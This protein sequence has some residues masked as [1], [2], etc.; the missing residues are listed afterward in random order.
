MPTWGRKPR[1]AEFLLFHKTLSSHLATRARAW[2]TSRFWPHPYTPRRR[3]QSRRSGDKAMKQA[4][5]QT[6][7]IIA[8]YLSALFSALGQR[9][10]SASKGGVTAASRSNPGP[11]MDWQAWGTQSG[12]CWRATRDGLRHLPAGPPKSCA[13]ENRL[14]PAPR[15]ARQPRFPARRATISVEYLSQGIRTKTARET[16]LL[17]RNSFLRCAPTAGAG[18]KCAPSR[19]RALFASRGEGGG[20]GASWFAEKFFG[21]AFLL[22]RGL[23]INWNKQAI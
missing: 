17:N 6:L 14:T 13:P 4:I 21:N 1:K 9:K 18:K 20:S 2:H 23:Q 22:Q 5:T 12:L 8:G 11:S 19:P 16:A 3:E 15:D 10:V 7:Q